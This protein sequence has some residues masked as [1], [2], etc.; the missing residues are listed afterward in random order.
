MRV[1]KVVFDRVS[2]IKSTVITHDPMP[3]PD[4]GAQSTKLISTKQAGSEAT[5]SDVLT[6]LMLMCEQDADN[7]N[8]PKLWME[9]SKVLKRIFNGTMNALNAP[10]II[11]DDVKEYEEAVKQD[12]RLKAGL[13]NGEQNLKMKI[14]AKVYYLAIEKDG[15][16]TSKKAIAAKIREALIN[17]GYPASDEQTKASDGRVPS[18]RTIETKW[19]ALL[20]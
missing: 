1:V 15:H 5:T 14:W 11:A 12:Q 3:S 8:N 19:L 4:G 18:A 10:A 2:G 20:R 13:K 16:R 9:S 6:Y 7:I 17:A